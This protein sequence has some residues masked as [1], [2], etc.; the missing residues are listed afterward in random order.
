MDSIH[1]PNAITL[2]TA[3]G[4]PGTPL[5]VGQVVQAL[6]LEL[7][8][9]DVFRLQLPQATVDVRSDVL[10][11]VGSTITL[12]VKGAGAN[13]RLV[14]YADDAR[15]AVPAPQ[16]APPAP[17]AAPTL[18]GK[19]PV[20]EAVII[21]RAPLQPGRAP[22]D[23]PVLRD[24]PPIAPARAPQPQQQS[25]IVT[26]E[27]ALGE[28]VRAAATKQSGLAPLFADI[29]QVAGA[30]PEALPVPLPVRAAAQQIAALRVPLDENLTASDV[31]QAFVRSG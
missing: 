28:A 27:R 13:A 1:L 19:H 9:S 16:A 30:A 29:E 10:L 5:Q 6:V 17:A 14:V 4:A 12:A 31:K 15:P 24:A 23:A 3:F 8:E 25:Q 2:P 18:T 7:I 20:G 11:A 26:P 22:V 21:A